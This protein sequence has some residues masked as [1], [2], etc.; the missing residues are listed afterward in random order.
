MELLDTNTPYYV[1]VDYAHTP[2]GISNLLNFVHTLDINRSIVVIG[3]AG[4]RDYLKRPKVGNAV[5]N[6]AS[7]AIFTYEDPRSE[8]PKDICEDI[9]SEL[10][11]D[12]DNYEIVIDRHEAIEKAVMMAK[13]KD[14]VLI[15]GKGNET[16]QKLKNET[17]YFNDIE[18]AYSAVKKRKELEKVAS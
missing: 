14:M 7:Y 15:L 8:D 17:I 9:I 4:E 3:Q 2:N 11:K 13:D 12:H 1:M 18:E 6:N 10:K 5:V 16:Y